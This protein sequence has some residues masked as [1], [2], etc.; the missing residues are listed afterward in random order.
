ML[1][2]LNNPSYVVSYVFSDPCREV[3]CFNHAHSSCTYD[4]EWKLV[5][6]HDIPSQC[7]QSLLNQ[8]IWNISILRGYSLLLSNRFSYHIWEISAKDFSCTFAIIDGESTVW[9]CFG[10]YHCKEVL[11]L[12]FP[13]IPCSCLTAIASST[14]CLVYPSKFLLIVSIMNIASPWLLP[15]VFPLHWRSYKFFMSK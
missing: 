2:Q 5:D 10:T 14:S 15:D 1:I 11:S 9:N 4:E 8:I 13:I 12:E 7:Y 6:K 3:P